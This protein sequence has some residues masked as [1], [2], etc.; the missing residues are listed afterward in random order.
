[1][2]AKYYFGF[3]ILSII[4]VVSCQD[5]V[6]P[7]PGF[8]LEDQAVE[9]RRDTA[10]NYTV[11]MGM[12]VPNGV[13]KIEVINAVNYELLDEVLSYQHQTSFEF[14]YKID[15]RSFLRDT[16]LYYIF[17]VTDNDNRTT[18]R[19]FKLIVKRFSFPEIQLVGGK[20]LSVVVPF[21]QLK[22]IV[23]TGLNKL[24]SVQVLFKGEEKFSY[25]VPAD[26]AIYKYILS[27]RIGF[28]A[29]ETGEE[30]KM[31]IIIKDR[32]NQIDT[33]EILVRKSDALKL[34]VSVNL[35]SY[36]NINIKIDLNYDELNRINKF[37]ITYPTGSTRNY[38]LHYNEMGVV[39][40][41]YYKNKYN[42]GNNY[43]IQI[44]KYKEGTTQLDQIIRRDEYRDDNGSIEILVEGNIEAK[45]FQYDDKGILTSFYG[46]SATINMEYADPFGTGESVFMDFWQTYKYYDILAKNR[47]HFTAFQPVYMPT[48]ID[49]LP[50]FYSFGTDNTTI[51]LLFYNKYIVTGCTH[52]S[53]EYTGNYLFKPNYTYE[54]DMDG[55]LTTYTENYLYNGWQQRVNVFTFNY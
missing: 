32:K 15:L 50:P 30:Y 27:Q 55:N 54:T 31:E 17:K 44:F 23:S 3:L 49:G 46:K 6:F 35:Y 29:L 43:L 48:F 38:I 13:Q 33:T 8:E 37:V 40:T 10:E 18:N 1:M 28:G 20:S 14:N 21:Y 19:G 2:N 24:E 7:D 4:A 42:T 51:N 39:D 5:P 22:G 9:V 53:T 41:F 12:K 16:V 36:N 11:K 34:P 25:S 52:T 26:S 45:N 47:Q